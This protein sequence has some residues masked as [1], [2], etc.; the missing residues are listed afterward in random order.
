MPL[1]EKVV[2]MIYEIEDGK[3]EMG[4]H[5]IEELEALIKELGVEL[6]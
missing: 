3:R 4:W 1:N 5:N 2:N 6:P